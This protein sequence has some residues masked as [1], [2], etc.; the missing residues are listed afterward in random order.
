M[1]FLRAYGLA[2]KE[3]VA[4]TRGAAPAMTPFHQETHINTDKYLQL[5]KI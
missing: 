5:Y 3:F 4:V 2:L 1:V